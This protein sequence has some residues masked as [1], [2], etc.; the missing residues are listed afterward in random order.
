MGEIVTPK[1]LVCIQH[2]VT[3]GTVTGGAKAAGVAVKTVYEWMK[4][5]AFTAELKDA[6][7]LAIIEFG[8]QLVAL[9]ALTAAALRDGLTDD[10]IQV[11]LRA[12]QLM[13]D[14]ILKIR[15]HSDLSARLAELEAAIAQSRLE[16]AVTANGDPIPAPVRRIDYRIGLATMPQNGDDQE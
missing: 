1:Q 14:G 16:A 2:M 4:Q 11:R 15:E 12:A 5:P 7:N 3:T 10:S 8:R 13:T 9:A 6:E